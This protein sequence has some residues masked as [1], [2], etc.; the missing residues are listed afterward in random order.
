MNEHKD[1]I[2][3]LYICGAL[4]GLARNGKSKDIVYGRKYLSH[5]DVFVRFAATQLIRRFGNQ[6]DLQ[7]IVETAQ[8]GLYSS[9]SEFATDTALHISRDKV[10]TAGILLNLNE[11]SIAKVVFRFLIENE[12]YLDSAKE[13]LRSPNDKVRLQALAYLQKQK[14]GEELEVILSEYN[15]QNSYYYNVVCYLDRIL[16]ASSPL[17]ELFKQRLMQE[18]DS[19]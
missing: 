6:S 16:Y 1:F 18:L 4:E 10:K 7:A 5:P 17:K 14:T 2:G 9:L 19:N 11:P 13:L 8:S 3:S 12:L 15:S